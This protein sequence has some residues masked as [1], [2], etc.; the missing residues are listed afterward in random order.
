MSCLFVD[1]LAPEL[2]EKI[3]FYVLDHDGMPLRHVTRLQPFVKKLT[4]VDG[5]L[6]FVN[7]DPAE[8]D[9]KKKRGNYAGDKPA[10]NTAI[11]FTCKKIYTEGNCCAYYWILSTC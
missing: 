6:P 11:L 9:P 7:E 8:R 5:E 1:K 3:Y 2:R 4:G 10:A